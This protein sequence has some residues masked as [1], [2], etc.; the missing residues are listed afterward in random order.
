MWGPA[1]SFTQEEIALVFEESGQ[2]GLA[3][4]HLD[5][6]NY[7]SLVQSAQIAPTA[8]L[9]GPTWS[10]DGER[11]AFTATYSSFRHADTHIWAISREG[12][13]L[14][15]LADFPHQEPFERT[16]FSPRWSPDGKRILF[17]S[18]HRHEGWA[19]HYHTYIY[20]M[21]ADGTDITPLGKEAQYAVWSPDGRNILYLNSGALWIASIAGGPP[22][23]LTSGVPYIDTVTWIP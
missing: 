6:S 13:D 3:V 5:G 16:D 10:L 21:S 9:G 22:A 1:W 14:T 18:N 8:A 17:I 4:V 20:T 11:L 23:Q 19:E 12:S 7:R 2:H 15:V